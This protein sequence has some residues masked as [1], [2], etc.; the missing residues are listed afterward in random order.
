MGVGPDAAPFLAHAGETRIAAA[1]V[2]AVNPYRTIATARER[3]HQGH[4][5][6]QVFTPPG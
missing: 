1:L 4:T 2:H 6:P 3:S 5:G